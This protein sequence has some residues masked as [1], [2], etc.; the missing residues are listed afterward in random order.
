MNKPYIIRDYA[1][2]GKAVSYW[3]QECGRWIR[4]LD[5]ATIY[6]TRGAAYEAVN[7]AALG[8]PRACGPAPLADQAQAPSQRKAS[9]QYRIALVRQATGCAAWEARNYLEAEEWDVADAV[10]SY[11]G[12]MADRM[13]PDPTDIEEMRVE[14]FRALGAI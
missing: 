14:A 6:E 8:L 2:A 1:G 11:R 5:A 12:D 13:Q 7:K 9:E 10:L 3:N 4:S